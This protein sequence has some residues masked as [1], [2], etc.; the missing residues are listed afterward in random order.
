MKNLT[1]LEEFYTEIE[2]DQIS[3]V[4]FYTN[5]CPDCLRSKMYMPKLEKEY[6][7]IRFYNINRDKM[8]DLSSYLGIYGIPSFLLFKNGDEIGRFV[9]KLGKSYIEVKEFIDS[10]I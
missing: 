6:S 9:S 7:N 5:W 2:S 1:N 8:L 4:Y 3:L 10:N